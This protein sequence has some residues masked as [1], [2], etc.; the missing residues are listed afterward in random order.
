MFGDFFGERVLPQAEPLYSL[1][2]FTQ[3]PS[4]V[5]QS[6]SDSINILHVSAC[7]EQVWM[8]RLSERLCTVNNIMHTNIQDCFSAVHS[9]HSSCVPKF[10]RLAHD[11]PPDNVYSLMTT[12]WGL[13]IPNLVVSVVGGEGKEKVK[14]WVRDVIRQGLVRAAQ[15]TGN[16]SCLSIFSSVMS[17]WNLYT[18]LSNESQVDC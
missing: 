16:L 5:Q 13:P 10:L 7:E 9:C 2:L 6:L 1:S 17:A 4:Y 14:P 15:S 11:T 3:I 18:Y 12:Q 8:S